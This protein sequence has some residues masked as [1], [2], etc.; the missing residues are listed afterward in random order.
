MQSAVKDLTY[1]IDQYTSHPAWLRRGGL[2][3]L[4]QFNGWGTGPLGPKYLTPAEWKSVFAKL[5]RPV[6]YARQNLDESYHPPIQ[7]AYVWWTPDTEWLDRFPR[8]AS[9][10]VR[11]GRLDFFS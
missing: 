8:R 4:Y 2:P 11:E 3:F 7:G 5:P 9:E 10:M 1:I 6:V